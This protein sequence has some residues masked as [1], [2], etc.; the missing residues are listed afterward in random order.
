VEWGVQIVNKHSV[1]KKKGKTKGKGIYRAPVLSL[2]ALSG[3]DHTVLPA[4]CTIP[5]FTL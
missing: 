3:M 5:S 2:K 4:N 1:N